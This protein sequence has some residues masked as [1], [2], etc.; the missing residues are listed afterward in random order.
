M[1]TARAP[2]S[3]IESTALA[4]DERGLHEGRRRYRPHRGPRDRRVK[5]PRIQVPSDDEG[6]TPELAYAVGLIA[7]DGCLSP[8]GK[9]VV[10]VSKDRDLLETFK[11]CL[12][13]QAPIGTNHGYYRVQI[14]DVTFFAWLERIGLSPRKS[15]TLGAVAVPDGVFIHFARGLLDGDGSIKVNTVIPNPHRYPLHTYQ[16]LRV[17][18]HSASEAHLTWLRSEL[19][20]LLGSRG[21]STVRSKN[22]FHPMYLLRYSKHESIALLSALYRDPLWPR[23]VRKWSTWNDF[24][25]NGKPT[26]IWSR[27]SGGT[28]D[29]RGS[30]TPVGASP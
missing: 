5:Y 11:A 27:R 28:G 29:T 17:E 22:R 24:C 12:G 8:D 14:V 19:A 15:L 23:L 20:R 26:R 16:R 13:T 7:T 3:I 25:V 30:Q 6:W 10:Q 1:D 4:A 21:W 9:T 18:F 2:G